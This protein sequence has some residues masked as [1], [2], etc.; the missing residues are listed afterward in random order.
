MASGSWVASK[1]GKM[2]VFEENIT[3]CGNA[4]DKDGLHKS[5]KNVE[6]VL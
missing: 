1:Q 6:A 4:T 3:Y 5:A 2:R